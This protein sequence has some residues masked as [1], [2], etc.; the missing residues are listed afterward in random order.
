MVTCRPR[1]IGDPVVLLG[2]G[3]YMDRQRVVNHCCIVLANSNCKQG[4][5]STQ[6]SN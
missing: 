6:S 3:D 4:V 2:V 1:I 5:E